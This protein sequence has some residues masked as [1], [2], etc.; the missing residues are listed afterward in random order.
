MFEQIS[1]TY[2]GQDAT[3]EIVIML[4]VAFALGF[5]C[6][7]FIGRS[8][9]HQLLDELEKSET[10]QSEL[11]RSALRLDR[12]LRFV[13]EKLAQIHAEQKEQ[14]EIPDERTLHILKSSL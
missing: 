11:R 1:T 3:L 4:S 2:T 7:Y 14:S 9:Q 5:L 10:V 8:Q 6:R 13:E 12:K